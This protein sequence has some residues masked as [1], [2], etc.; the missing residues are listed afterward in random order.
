MT[1]LMRNEAL[2][3]LKSHLSVRDARTLFYRMEVMKQKVWMERE[4]MARKMATTLTL[5][6][7]QM[8]QTTMMVTALQQQLMDPT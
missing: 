6:P 2:K 8:V 7:Q 4:Q 5:R 1:R 3:G